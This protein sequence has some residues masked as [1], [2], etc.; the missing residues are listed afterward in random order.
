MSEKI[1]KQ[2]TI[3]PK[4]ILRCWWDKCQP[5][6]YTPPD[7]MPLAGRNPKDGAKIKLHGG[8]APPLRRRRRAA[9]P[10]PPLY[11]HTAVLRQ[12]S[13]NL[14]KDLTTRARRLR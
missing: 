2:K 5:S 9:L 6:S 13:I 1:C 4:K 11:I 7:L 14:E 10:P 12:I 8:R 3:P